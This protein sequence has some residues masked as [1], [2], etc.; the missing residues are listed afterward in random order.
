MR[1]N[2][3]IYGLTTLSLLSSAAFSQTIIQPGGTVGGATAANQT[4]GSQLTGLVAGT[5]LVGKFGI[6]QTT[7][8]TTNAI[9]IAQIK[10][11]AANTAAA[12][13]LLVGL[14]DGTG[15]PLTSTAGALNVSGTITGST[16]SGQT[17]VQT[18]NITTNATDAVLPVSG[19]SNV[20]T[21]VSGTYNT[22]AAQFQL[23]LDGGA[24]YPAVIQST[25]TD[26]QTIES[27]TGNLTNTTRCW[28]TAAA[29]A[30]HFRVHTTSLSSGT[31]VIT[32]IASSD[33]LSYIPVAGLSAINGTTIVSGGVNGSLGVGGLAASGGTNAGNPD[34]IGG[35]FNTTQPTVTN[36]QAVDAQYTARGSAIV[37]SGVD[38]L[39]V[40]PGNTANTTPWLM[41]PQAS[42][43]GGYTPYFANAVKGTVLTI[44]G[45]AGKFAYTDLI[46]TD[47]APVYLQVFDTTGAVTLGTTAP[48]FVIPYAANAT[49]ANGSTE[50]G[51]HE[52]GYAITA[53]IKIAATTTPTGST[54]STNGLTG[55]I[56]FK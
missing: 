40:Q 54:P 3:I 2:K 16:T 56:G 33:D 20:T 49:A 7:P 34:K 1:I 18:T 19:Y 15:T 24:T 46:N 31:A 5:A 11:A 22:W 47:G 45:S 32:Q 55:T 4:N 38:A 8:G 51:E 48:T 6:D 35:A 28:N 21:C 37:A 50:R 36:G 13:T 29:G 39:T 43:T 10:G 42:T 52:L 12:G 23:S 41:S 30:T 25:R 44:S 27:A 9:S 26:T 53:G 17:P 14:A